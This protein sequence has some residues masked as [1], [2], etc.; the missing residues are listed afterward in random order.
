[1]EDSEAQV[2]MKEDEV[3]IKD[4]EGV[5]DKHDFSSLRSSINKV[6]VDHKDILLRGH[7]SFS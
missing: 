2:P 4:L 6:S 1:M 5:E 3:R 7:P